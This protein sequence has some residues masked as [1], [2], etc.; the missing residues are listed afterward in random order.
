MVDMPCPI[1]IPGHAVRELGFQVVHQFFKVVSYQFFPVVTVFPATTTKRF[2]HARAYVVTRPFVWVKQSLAASGIVLFPM[3][4]MITAVS[5]FFD[6]WVLWVF[7][8]IP[9]AAFTILGII[10]SVPPQ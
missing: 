6:G 3:F 7:F 1:I 2:C 9:F 8:A 10:I 5:L 4:E